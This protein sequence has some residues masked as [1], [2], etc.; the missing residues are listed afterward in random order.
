MEG[1]GN[2]IFPEIFEPF[3]YFFYGLN[4]HYRGFFLRTPTVTTVS[5]TAQGGDQHDVKGHFYS[6]FFVRFFKLLVVF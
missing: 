4:A 5:W 6:T 1:K 3:N 2:R